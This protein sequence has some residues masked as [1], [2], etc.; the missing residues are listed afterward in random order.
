MEIKGKERIK[1]ARTAE[2]GEVRI[3]PT[4]TS[5]S[6]LIA[7]EESQEREIISGHSN[8]LFFTPEFTPQEP[9]AIS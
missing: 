6:S 5:I 3:K 9:N 8:Q 7:Q 2:K 4:K 1:R